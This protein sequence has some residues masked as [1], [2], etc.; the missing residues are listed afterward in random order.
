[1]IALFLFECVCVVGWF[2]RL[3]VVVVACMLIYVLLC[4]CSR[5]CVCVSGCVS[6]LTWLFVCVC[7]RVLVCLYALSV[8]ASVCMRN[9][10]W[11]RVW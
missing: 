1:M 5:Y 8:S 2:P 9:C 11:V 7:V 4:G 6:A 10:C 3:C